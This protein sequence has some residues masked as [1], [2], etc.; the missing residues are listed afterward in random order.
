MPITLSLTVAIASLLVH[1]CHCPC[2]HVATTVALHYLR[3]TQPP[4]PLPS[5]LAR[6]CHNVAAGA[7]LP[8]P[9]HFCCSCE[10]FIASV[11]TCHLCRCPLQKRSCLATQRS[12][13]FLV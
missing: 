7:W 4:F 8:V 1:H 11:L 3:S 2:H 10:L 5:R 9:P 12:T 6:C 13:M